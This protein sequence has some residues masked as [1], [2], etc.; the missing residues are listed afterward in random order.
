[1]GNITAKT[2]FF[3]EAPK[4]D[5]PDASKPMIAISFDDGAV[6]L[7]H[8]T[9]DTTAAAIEE[10]APYIKAKGWQIATISEMYAAKGKSIPTGQVIK[11][12][13]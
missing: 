9:Y 10:L 12:V 6:V 11:R 7:C 13:C 4:A 1:M 3:S 5:K 2:A 8:E